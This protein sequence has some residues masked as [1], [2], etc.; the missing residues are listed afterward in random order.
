MAQTAALL[1]WIAGIGG[2]ISCLISIRSL[3]AGRGIPLVL[4]FPAFGGGSFERHGIET[5]ARLVSGLL[6]ICVVETVAGGLLWWD[7]R[8]GAILAI[9]AIPP[10]AV[11]WWGFALPYPPALALV[12]T[13]LIALTWKSLR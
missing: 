13:I 8:S 7:Q 2:G 10:G 4:G 6:A 9:A 1:L 3:L 11:Y 12:R 5:S